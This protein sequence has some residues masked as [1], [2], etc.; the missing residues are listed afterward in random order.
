MFQPLR[1]LFFLTALTSMSLMSVTWV[2]VASPAGAT[3]QLGDLQG[4]WRMRGYGTVFEISAG[5]MT[6]YDVTDISCQ[7]TRT[8]PLE[9]MRDEWTGIERLGT[10]YRFFENGGITSYVIE[11]L[12]HPPMNCRGLRAA[13]LRDPVLNFWV[14]WHAFRENYAFFDLRKVD[15]NAQY[16]SYRPRL[17]ADTSDAELIETFTRMLATLNDRHVLLRT[18]EQEIWT[19]APG[20]MLKLW[21]RGGTAANGDAGYGSNENASYKAA[22]RRHVTE[23]ILRGKFMD[24]ADEALTWGWAATG[25]GYLHV[26]SMRAGT[27]DLTE[28]LRRIDE[29]MKR[30]LSDLARARVII[31]DARFNTGG[32]DAVALRIAG[33]FTAQRRLAFTKKAV[34][35]GGY[36]EPQSIYIDP[37]GERPFLE[38]ILY[39]QSGS[40][41]SAAEIFTLAMMALPHVTRIGTPTLGTLSDTKRKTLPNGWTVSLSNEVYEAIDG[42]CYEGEGIPPQ[43][44]VRTTPEDTFAQRLERDIDTAVALASKR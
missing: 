2:A 3:V 18:P 22:I 42:K 29:G 27:V 1:S 4:T 15:W 7:V 8:Q 19:T 31:V 35:S 33:Y 23:E 6:T 10:G 17:S 14:L 37:A 34:V 24:A 16:A 30:A 26:A 9:A 36:T 20:E 40:T 25:V 44:R 32:Y 13:T 21:A 5:S 12:A 43:L 38:P 11:P 28:R 39:L 41:G